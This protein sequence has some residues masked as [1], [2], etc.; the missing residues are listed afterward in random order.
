MCDKW[1]TR[2]N[3]HCDVCE[4]SHFA[5]NQISLNCSHMRSKSQPYTTSQE[6]CDSPVTA[7]F[8][9]RADDIS[10]IDVYHTNINTDCLQP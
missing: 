3:V 9:L 5:L 1:K 4:I 8:N 10:H 6:I 2:D 7:N